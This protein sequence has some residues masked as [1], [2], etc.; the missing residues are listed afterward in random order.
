MLDI[1]D[2]TDY[3]LLLH[4][5]MRQQAPKGRGQRAA[6]ASYLKCQP[7]YI[8]HVL[9][10]R[11]DFSL[12]QM[13][14]ACRYFEFSAGSSHYA[15]IL[16]S[17]ERAGSRPLRDYYQQQI[18]ALRREA[19]ELKHKVGS[20]SEITPQ[21]RA[22]Y[23]SS[24]HYGAIHMLLTIP[25][26]QDTNSISQRLRLKPTVVS[27][28]LDF[29][30]NIGLIAFEGGTIKVLQESIHLDRDAP[31]V[32][33]MHTNHR[34]KAISALAESGDEKFHFSTYFSCSQE[35]LPKLR[36]KLLDAIESCAT[37]IKASPSETIAAIN[38]DFY[39]M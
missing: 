13:E 8:S 15:L 1:H 33:A 29:F 31:E 27:E 6:L 23:Y 3:R 30:R 36:K 19:L 26:F 9:S 14:A 17:R 7:T 16:L 2:Y 25:G 32:L 34:L 11:A 37:I 4:D 21:H 38:I 5:A 28:T 22:Q 10:G 24:W 20:H 12:E 39:E 35:L 18:Q